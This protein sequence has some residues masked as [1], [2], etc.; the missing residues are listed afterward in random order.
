MTADELE[1]LPEV[2]GQ[3]GL[4]WREEGDQIGYVKDGVT[5]EVFRDRAGTLVRQRAMH[6]ALRSIVNYFTAG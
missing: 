2:T 1:K 5:W 4:K 6:G 3:L